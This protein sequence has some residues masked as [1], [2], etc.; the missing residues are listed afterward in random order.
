MD[1]IADIKYKS[2]DLFQKAMENQSFLQVFYGDMEGDEDEM[3]LKNKLILLNKAIR[4]FQTDVCGCGQ[5]I[6]IQSM[7]SLIREIQGYI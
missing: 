7:K 6:R 5:G 1:E 3:A 2:N 4:D